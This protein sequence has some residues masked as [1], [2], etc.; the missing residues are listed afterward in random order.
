MVARSSPAARLAEGRSTPS[1]LKRFRTAETGVAA[2]E[3]ALILPVMVALLLGMSEITQA[4]GVDRKLTLVSRSLAD[5]SSRDKELTS[6]MLSD[7]FSAASVIMQPYDSSRLRMTISNM[8][9][10]K[11]GTNYTGKALW[12]CARGSG[13]QT[14]PS[15]VV[16][17]DVP[18]GF[19]N[20]TDTTKSYYM[21]IDVTLPYTPMF[22]KA[23]TGT[24]NLTENTPWPIRNDGTVTLKDSCPAST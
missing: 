16:Y 4:V 12:S 6:A 17:T 3:F 23:L 14:R 13:A 9:V 2:V 10:T 18:V 8:E 15:T 24:I 22:G 21:Q 20:A 1:R 5:L 7:V 11:T 19:R